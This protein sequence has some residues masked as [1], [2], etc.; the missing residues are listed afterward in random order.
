MRKAR[1]RFPAAENYW[2]KPKT[3]QHKYVLAKTTHRE[4]DEHVTHNLDT[5]LGATLP[6]RTECLEQS[7]PRRH[8]WPWRCEGASGEGGK[9]AS[10]SRVAGRLPAHAPCGDKH[11][12]PRA[13]SRSVKGAHI[14]HQSLHSGAPTAKR[15][16]GEGGTMPARG[17]RWRLLGSRPPREK[18]SPPH[19]RPHEGS[20]WL[21]LAFPGSAWLCLALSGSL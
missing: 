10:R 2:K 17:G 3:H 21:S 4:F 19:P 11:A 13:T 8:G 6:S 1:A 12:M 20:R 7:S 5:S 15:R 9:A 18:F 14:T 16:G